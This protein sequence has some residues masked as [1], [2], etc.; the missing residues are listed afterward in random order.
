MSSGCQHFWEADYAA[1]VGHTD[2]LRTIY[3]PARVAR[4][5]AL[6][7]HDPLVFA[8]HWAGSLAEWIRGYSGRSVERMDEA[9]ALARRI[10]HP[11]NLVFALTAGASSLIY[12]DQ[13][14]RL[15]EH[16]DG[17]EKVATNEALGPFAA[18]VLVDQWRGGAHIRRGRFETGLAL[19]KTGNDFWNE[20]GGRICNAMFGSWLVSGL[21]GLGRIDEALELNAGTIAHCRDTGDHFMEAECVRMRGEL[22]LAMRPPD[23]EAP[24]RLFQNAIA[25]AQ[26]QKAKSWEL[27]AATSLARLWAGQARRAE[28]NAVLAPVYSWFTEGFD[29]GDL[30]KANGLLAELS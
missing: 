20:S 11:F 28:A 18:Q 3:A 9:V 14:E 13:A 24:E 4:L 26:S 12:L 15:L 16:C 23:R 22:M 8:Q 5:V 25:I 1:A 17:A 10:G 2:N 29:T 6:T 27:R 7:N 21:H 19:A 30:R